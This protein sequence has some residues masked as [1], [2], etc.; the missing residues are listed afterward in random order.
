MT[1]TERDVRLSLR[2]SLSGTLRFNRV[3]IMAGMSKLVMGSEQLT[4]LYT[5]PLGYGVG[6]MYLIA[7]ME[8]LAAICLIVGYWNAKFTVAGAAALAIVMTGAV[9]SVLVSDMGI[10]TAL[11]PLVWVV[12]ALIVFF[13]KW[14][15]ALHRNSGGM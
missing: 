13:G 3:N 8:L 14:S 7:C 12:V 1:C 2:S 4:V 15:P 6:F 10:V 9:I 5:E 11:S